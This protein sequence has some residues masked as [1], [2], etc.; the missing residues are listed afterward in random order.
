MSLWTL[1]LDVQGTSWAKPDLGSNNGTKWPC[2]TCV[3]KNGSAASQAAPAFT[4]AHC[5]Q[6]C[7]QLLAP[8]GGGLVGAKLPDG[9]ARS[10]VAAGPPP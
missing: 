2:G 5:S 7:W 3:C 9:P 1:R 4:L 6:L 10:L 8:L